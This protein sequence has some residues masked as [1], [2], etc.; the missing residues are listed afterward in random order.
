MHVVQRDV[1]AVVEPVGVVVQLDAVLAPGAGLAVGQA[2]QVDGDVRFVTGISG[3]TVTVDSA[4]TSAAAGL[5]VYGAFNFTPT[6]GERAARSIAAGCDGTGALTLL[7]QRY[8]G[9]T[10]T[11]SGS[12]A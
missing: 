3:T 6:L 10:T 4:V 11:A 8:T 5:N 2:V 12:P 1:G 7:W 9:A